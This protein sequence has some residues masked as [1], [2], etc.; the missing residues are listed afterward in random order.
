MKKKIIQIIIVLFIGLFG[1]FIGSNIN[2]NIITAA[3]AEPVMSNSPAPYVDC[4]R[5]Y[6]YGKKYIIFTSS[7][8]GLFVIRD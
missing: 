1:Y 4:Q 5:M 6:V 3:K 8:G 7:S 2:N